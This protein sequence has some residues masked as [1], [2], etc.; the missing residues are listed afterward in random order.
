MASSNP[1]IVQ[2]LKGYNVNQALL[3][4]A[5]MQAT[6]NRNP[7]TIFR[8]VL[9]ESDIENIDIIK[10]LN[11]K[12]VEVN[13]ETLKKVQ[14]NVYEIVSDNKNKRQNRKRLIEENHEFLN[15][16]KN[17]SD[18]DFS[19]KVVEKVFQ[20]ANSG[21]YVNY[22][23]RDSTIA[24]NG[25]SFL[26][27]RSSAIYP[28]NEN[29]IVEGVNTSMWYIGGS[30]SVTSLH[31]EDGDFASMNVLLKGKPKIWGFI[32]KKEF[33]VLALKVKS[34]LNIDKEC[35]IYH[36]PGLVIHHNLLKEWGINM[37]YVIQKAG[38]MVYVGEATMHF[39]VNVG[40]NI[41]KQ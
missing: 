12:S 39:V 41:A 34:Y 3:Y 5:T 32:D 22:Y 26:Q 24:P 29:S 21:V 25:K 2:N 8:D 4:V 23:G 38:D 30:G 33:P 19:E 40:L 6:I 17:E 20:N 13:C 18:I 10:Y 9:D 15:Q 7:V 31:V 11:D 14:H 28:E 16:A 36:K 1:E 35:R 27:T 37:Q